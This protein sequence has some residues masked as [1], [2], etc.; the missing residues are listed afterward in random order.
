MKVFPRWKPVWTEPR[1]KQDLSENLCIITLDMYIFVDIL[2]KMLLLYRY[3]LE[4]YPFIKLFFYWNWFFFFPMVGPFSEMPLAGSITQTSGSSCC[5]LRRAC[6]S[7]RHPSLKMGSLLCC[8]AQPFSAVLHELQMAAP[9]SSCEQA[10]RR[11][12]KLLAACSSVIQ[13]KGKSSRASWDCSCLH[14]WQ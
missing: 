8:W 2:L 3:F 14:Y 5:E 10:E 4:T 9:G 13:R 6:C 7:R 11:L 1:L 12:R